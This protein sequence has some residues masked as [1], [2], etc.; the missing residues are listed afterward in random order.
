[1]PGL[2]RAAARRL[3]AEAGYPRGFDVTLLAVDAPRPYL[4]APLAEAAQIRDDLARV[5]IRAAIRQVPTWAEYLETAGRGD[6]DL[7]DLG[8]GQVLERLA[9]ADEARGPLLHQGL[10]GAGPHVVRRGH[11]EPVGPRVAH[12]EQLARDHGGKVA[13]AGQEVGGLAHGAHDVDADIRPA[14]Q[15]DRLDAVERAVERGPQQVVHPRV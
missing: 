14:A 3:L 11:R 13:I 10:G 9:A 4:P 7:A 6:Y 12:R 8:R 1:D 5:G 15:R 2:D